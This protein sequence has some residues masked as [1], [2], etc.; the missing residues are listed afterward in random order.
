MAPYVE[1]TNS[2]DLPEHVKA[3]VAEVALTK[4]G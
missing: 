2:D 4:D 1:A 3:A